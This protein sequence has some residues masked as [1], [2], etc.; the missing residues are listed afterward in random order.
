MIKTASPQDTFDAIFGSGATMYSWWLNAEFTG[1]D[2]AGTIQT[3]DWTVKVP[4]E[5]GDRGETTATVDHKSILKAARQIIKSAP[6]FASDALVRE[7]RNLIF[8]ADELDFDANSADEIL[9]VLVLGEIVF[10]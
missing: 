2:S 9:Q 10:G 6:K 3:T 4:A 1:I 8:D 7:S 5:N